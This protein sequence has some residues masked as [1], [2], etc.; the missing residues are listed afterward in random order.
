MFNGSAELIVQ[1]IPETT[2]EKGK[3]PG[4]IFDNCLP[5]AA[6]KKVI[7]GSCWGKT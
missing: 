5:L 2:P 1:V 4:S 3:I 6:I 7:R